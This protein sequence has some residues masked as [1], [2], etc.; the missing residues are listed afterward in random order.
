MSWK[1]T[2]PDESFFPEI[3]R[4]LGSHSVLGWNTPAE[5]FCPGMERLQGSSSVLD[6][7]DS[8]GIILSWEGKTPG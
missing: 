7:N 3:E 1:G 4:L 6:C 8:R 2:T 5:A